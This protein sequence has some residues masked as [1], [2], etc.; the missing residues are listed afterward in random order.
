MMYRSIMQVFVKK[1]SKAL[2]FK[3][4][5]VLIEK[6]SNNNRKLVCIKIL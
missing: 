6:Y 3:K 5:N 4:A 1:S 2:G